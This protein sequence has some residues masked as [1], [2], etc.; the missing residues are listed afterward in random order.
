MP[1]RIQATAASATVAAMPTAT[2]STVL[3]APTATAI[4]TTTRHQECTARAAH[5]LHPRPPTLPLPLA[6]GAVHAATLAHP[7]HPALSAAAMLPVPVPVACPRLWGR[8]SVA[9]VGAAVGCACRPHQCVRA[10]T[11]P[12]SVPHPC[13]HPLIG[14]WH[15]GNTLRLATSCCFSH[16]RSR[17]PAA[18]TSTTI[19]NSATATAPTTATTP[20]TATATATATA[21]SR[22]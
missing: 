15:R 19:T 20:T 12:W 6:T 13:P 5:L 10:A 2:V 22:W 1:A 17:Q 18:T 14:R 8:R 3:L 7:L 9:R 4:L 16:T 11:G 21:H